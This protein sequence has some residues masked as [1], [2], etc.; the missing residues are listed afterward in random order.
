MIF[1]TLLRYKKQPQL[2]TAV[3]FASALLGYTKREYKKAFVGHQ[4]AFKLRP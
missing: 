3:V 4:I 2:K 1:F